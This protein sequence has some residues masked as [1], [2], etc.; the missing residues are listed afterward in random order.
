MVEI[1]EDIYNK[2]KV[3]SKLVLFLLKDNIDK[4]QFILKANHFI[5]L[6][7]VQVEIVT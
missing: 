6:E 3:N 7:M 2:V 5:I 1:I 4:N